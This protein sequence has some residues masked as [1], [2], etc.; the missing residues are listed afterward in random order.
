MVEKKGSLKL[1]WKQPK[2]VAEPC[3][4]CKSQEH[5]SGACPALSF[6]DRCGEKGHFPK[7]C[8]YHTETDE[9]RGAR[10]KEEKRNWEHQ[11]RKNAKHD[12]TQEDWSRGRSLSPS[13]DDV[14][15]YPKIDRPFTE[16][17]RERARK[18]RE[19]FQARE[20]RQRARQARE[21]QEKA[22]TEVR[23]RAEASVPTHNSR[24]GSSDNMS[25][26]EEGVG[27]PARR[28]RSAASSGSPAPR[29]AESSSSALPLRPGRRVTDSD[30]EEARLRCRAQQAK[31]KAKAARRSPDTGDE[32]VV[33]RRASPRRP[34]REGPARR[35][36][37][38]PS[39]S[40][41]STTHSAAK[42]P[43][44]AHLE[45]A[46]RPSGAHR[47]RPAPEGE[48]ADARGGDP[49]NR[50]GATERPPRQRDGDVRRAER[51]AR[52]PDAGASPPRKQRP[53]ER[54]PERGTAV[55]Q[56]I[57]KVV[58]AEVARPETVPVPDPTDDGLSAH[59]HLLLSSKA[60]Q[61]KVKLQSDHFLCPSW[62]SLPEPGAR[63]EVRKGG[64]KL[65]S[66]Q[67]D[68]NLY[69]LFGRGEGIV[70]FVVEHP[71]ASRVHFALIHD[72]AHKAA[73]VYDLGSKAKT[74]IDGKAIP[75]RKAVLL[76][77]GAILTVGESTRCYILRRRSL[78]EQ[79][80]A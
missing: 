33:E 54:S 2:K 30:E 58:V 74:R 9:Q 31:A 78:W 56:P 10:R 70:D 64:Q 8:P 59:Q 45:I 55:E 15:P 38:D 65:P 29:N 51:R 6:C 66:I 35:R 26:S 28:R 52:S 47:H 60:Y 19:W 39:S 11:L 67:M 21:E 49:R 20:A 1:N 23:G 4:F 53:P 68:R 36:H 42:G 69:Y 41:D 37:Q 71:S 24:G 27:L 50:T 48:G 14:C 75:P 57:Q 13:D 18:R 62:A 79:E 12:R 3:K 32:A 77:D 73:Y 80:D 34:V 16:D 22:P 7:V 72:G 43:P 76:P 5:E 44:K 61:K 46:Q 40:P 63:F 25:G 17:E